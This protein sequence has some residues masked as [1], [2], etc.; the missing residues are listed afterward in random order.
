MTLWST[1]RAWL[2]TPAPTA[3]IEIAADRV[4]AAA[5]APGAAPAVAAHAAAPMPAGALAPAAAA[6]NVRDREAAAA[7]V[8]DAVGRL[9]RR[10]PRASL[11]VPDSAAKVS[12]VR[13]DT[14]PARRAELD[15]LIRWRVRDAIPFRLEEAQV[16]WD[17]ADAA[18]GADAGPRAFVVVVMRRD[19]VEEYEALAAAAGA[20]PGIVLPASLAVLNLA[21]A[22]ANGADA[23]ADRL[24]VHAAAG[25]NSAAILRGRALL[26]F[27][28]Q[29][30]DREGDLTDLVHRTAMY[31]ED[32][33]G[34]AGIQKALLAADDPDVEAL[35]GRLASGLGAPVEPLSA[36]RGPDG[37]AA[38]PAAVGA[39]LA[40]GRRA[41]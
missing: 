20:R 29:A 23:S 40:A 17:A 14:A 4:S 8:R 18:S 37:G 9:P 13:F 5:A 1:A 41:G 11:V 3:A 36:P 24:L 6:A 7:A 26:L 2:S 15:R 22:G 32:R 39:L 12:V 31:Y 38:A 28:N 35:A 27:R 34:G 21:L 19:I 16:A 33:I 10:A 30:G 25:Y